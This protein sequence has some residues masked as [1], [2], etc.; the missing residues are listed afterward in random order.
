MKINVFMTILALVASALVGYAFY[1]AGCTT[2]HTVVSTVLFAIFL[3]M[4]LGLYV[5]NY[6]RTSILLKVT[7]FVFLVAFLVL[8]IILIAVKVSN[9]T[10]IITNGLIAVIATLICYKLYQAKQ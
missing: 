9:P 8:D 4:G 3:E 7:S 6:P 10:F 1:Y 2:L 5:E